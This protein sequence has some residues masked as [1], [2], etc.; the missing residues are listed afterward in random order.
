MSKKRVLFVGEYSQ[1]STGF[2]AIA[3]HLLPELYAKHGDKFEIAELACY[4]PE[5]HPNA[6]IVPWKVYGNRPAQGDNRSNAVFDSNPQNEFGLWAFDK[7]LLDFQPHVVV[8]WRDPWFDQFIHKHPYRRLFKFVHMPTCDGTPQKHEWLSDTAS[9]DLILTYSFWAKMVL[10]RETNGAIKV[11]DVASP[12]IDTEAFKPQNKKELRKNF[13]VPE[14]TMIFGACMRNQPRKLFP[15]F[16]RGFNHYLDVC[17][18]NNRYDLI[19]KSFLWFH[20]TYPDLGWDFAEE[21]KRHNLGH[22]IL[23][24][25]SCAC[26]AV[27]PSFFAGESSF[28]RQCNKRTATMPNTGNGLSR[29]TLGQIYNCW[30]LMVQPS[31][32]L[33]KNQEIQTNQGWKKISEIKVGDKVLTTNGFEKVLDVI[34]NNGSNKD[35]IKIKVV[36]RYDELLCTSD[37]PILGYNKDIS[38]HTN[39][40]LR[41]EVGNKIGHGTELPEPYFIEAGKLAQ[42]DIVF[43]Y[44]D[45][46]EIDQNK[47]D[48]SLFLNSSQEY[49][50]ND[51]D[52]YSMKSPSNI[53]RYIDITEEYCRFLGMFLGDGSASS[54]SVKITVSNKEEENIKLAKKFLSKIDNRVKIRKYKGREAS[55]IILHSIVALNYFRQ[56]YNDKKE[57]IIPNWVVK[58]PKHKQ[59]EIV[60]GLIM[61]DGSVHVTKRNT[62]KTIICNTSKPLMDSIIDIL[63]RLRISYGCCVQYRGGN[64]KPM[65]RIEIYGDILNL[66]PNTKIT[67]PSIKYIDNKII[68][69]VKSIENISREE[70]VFDLTIENTHNFQ[71]KLGI[72]HNCE[73]F[74]M[75]INEAKAC[76]CPT[77]V[78]DHSAMTEQG[79]SPGG[80]IL[81]VSQLVQES[82][83]Q[84]NQLRAYIASDILGELLYNFSI[85]PESERTKMG[86]DGSKFVHEQ[87]S[88]EN[89]ASIWVRALEYVNV[90]NL[91]SW[92]SPAKLI[93]PVTQNIP[94]NLPSIDF[95]KWCYYN[96]LQSPEELNSYEAYKSIQ[97][98]EKGCDM[99]IDGSG[100]AKREPIDYEKYVK[101]LLAKVQNYNQVEMKRINKFASHDT[102]RVAV[103]EI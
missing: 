78:T 54:G 17:K 40:T 53:N 60:R 20:T 43:S 24:T 94:A 92:D 98:L 58:L 97:V 74:G 90:E 75:P 23:F 16:M 101:Y 28:C 29:E 82:Q 76:G 80:M 9:A 71:T 42:G 59:L 79:N 48:L 100:R 87:Y 21:I 22:K 77:L 52:I 81:P 34:E 86:L 66:E 51:H 91:P 30:D 49:I 5:G 33:E 103:M 1:V 35:M 3:R 64:R 4:L 31:I 41:E 26:G 15:E 85:K 18:F 12:P 69:V 55:D 57:K 62:S 8:T 99:S 95:V 46:E 93:N 56:F 38:T 102:K 37:H 70:K 68:R 96:I 27:Y 6:D 47:H 73:G 10:E 7:V 65:Y 19:N 89:I 72:V 11:F 13:G 63:H 67:N 84:T 88:I 50:V 61:S 2:A 36:G 45:D 25:Y 14:D 39:R 83:H 32:C 44:I